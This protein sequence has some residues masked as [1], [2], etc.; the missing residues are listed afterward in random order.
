MKS[1]KAPGADGV[2]AE[3][4]K[5]GDV[6][7]ETLTEIFKKKWE[8]EEIPVGWK[9]GLIV[10]L[11]NKG[12]IRLCANWRGITLRSI[13]STVFCSVIL[14]GISTALDPILRKKPAEFRKGRS[15]GEHIFT[16]RQILEQCQEW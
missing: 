8:E 14:N 6:I 11:S 10:K 2:N 15:C 4:L 3:M 9:T 1:G 13:T 7:T 5:T 16:I 12:N